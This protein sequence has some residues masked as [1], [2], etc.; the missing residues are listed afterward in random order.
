MTTIKAAGDV[1]LLLWTSFTF[2]TSDCWRIWPP[3]KEA[4]HC[5]LA[6]PFNQ[7]NSPIMRRIHDTCHDFSGLKSLSK[8]CCRQ[9]AQQ[10]ETHEQTQHQIKKYRLLPCCAISDV[11]FWHLWHDAWQVFCTWCYSTGYGNN[12][13]PAVSVWARWNSKWIWTPLLSQS[14]LKIQRDDSISWTMRRTQW[15]R[16]MTR[17]HQPFLGPWNKTSK[18]CAMSKV[19]RH[20]WDRNVGSMQNETESWP[21]GIFVM[22]WP[23]EE[24]SLMHRILNDYWQRKLLSFFRQEHMSMKWKKLH[25]AAVCFINT[26]ASKLAFAFSLTINSE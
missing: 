15:F 18:Y 7:H 9:Y 26:R 23:T 17:P 22:K 14:I 13:L 3:I 1:D 11:L 12:V 8:V 25:C 19:R 24:D 10:G 2:I 5:N 20:W 6:P 21:F 16:L 4:S